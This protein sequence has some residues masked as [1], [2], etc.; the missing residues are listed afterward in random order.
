MRI[1][2]FIKRV[3]RK[4]TFGL[5]GE[6]VH[7]EVEKL[8]ILGEHVVMF[9]IEYKNY[10]IRQNLPTCHIKMLDITPEDFAT[11]MRVKFTKE[12]ERL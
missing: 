8:F 9:T 11:F 1:N 2:R 10:R 6:G 3:K 7:V 5:L 12:Y 4:L